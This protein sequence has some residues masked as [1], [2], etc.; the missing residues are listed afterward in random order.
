[1]PDFFLV[2]LGWTTVY[3][4]FKVTK[5]LGLNAMWAA[6][7]NVYHTDFLMT[8]SAKCPS[9]LT[10][11]FLLFHSW[12]LL[13]DK[14]AKCIE[15]YPFWQQFH[16]ENR[17]ST[18]E[19]INATKCV[20]LEILTPSVVFRWKLSILNHKR[21][22]KYIKIRG[23]LFCFERNLPYSKGIFNIQLS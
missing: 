16:D 21:L 9:V 6:F 4:F 14:A 5:T 20:F 8:N 3:S 1:M 22:S 11:K 17:M 15:F 10:Y 13:L 18:I 19:N 2:L 12:A 23:H 7:G